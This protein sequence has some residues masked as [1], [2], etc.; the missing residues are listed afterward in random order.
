MPF[1]VLGLTGLILEWSD[2]MSTEKSEFIYGTLLAL[3]LL[4]TIFGVISIARFAGKSLD[5]QGGS[6]FRRLALV[7]FISALPYAIAVLYSNFERRELFEGLA[8]TLFVNGMLVVVFSLFV[9][10][11]LF[12]YFSILYLLTRWRLKKLYRQTEGIYPR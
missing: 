12:V 3:A 7:S 8:K 9:A 2:R 1:L 6:V 11:F 4:S 5:S 10:G